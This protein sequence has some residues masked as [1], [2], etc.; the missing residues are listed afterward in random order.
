MLN[1]VMEFDHPV[2]IGQDGQVSSAGVYA[3]EVSWSSLDDDPD[4]AMVDYLASQGW[5]ALSG[6]TGQYAYRGPVMHQSEYVGGALERDMM[7]DPG[8]YAIV[9]VDD[10]EDGALVGWLVVRKDEPVL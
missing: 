3:P 4:S 2:R 10:I 6:Y 5:S 1:S 8:V 7:A 9:A